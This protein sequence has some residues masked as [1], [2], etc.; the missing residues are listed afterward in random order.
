MNTKEN[1]NNNNNNK[2]E[3]VLGSVGVRLISFFENSN[4]SGPGSSFSKVRMDQVRT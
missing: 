2:E 1:G 4:M 3:F